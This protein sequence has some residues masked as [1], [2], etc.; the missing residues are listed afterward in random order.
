[1]RLRGTHILPRLFAALSL[2]VMLVAGALASFA[3]APALAATPSVDVFVGYADNLRANPANFPTPWTD[4]E[5]IFLGCTNCTYDAGAVRIANNTL[6]SVTVNALAIRMDTCVFALW[7]SALPLSLAPGQQLIVTQTADGADS[8]CTSNGHMDTSDVGPGG[9][10]WAGRCDNSGIIPEVDVTID[11]VSSSIPDTGRVLNTGGV[12]KAD[13]FGGANESTQWVPIQSN[14]CESASLTLDPS[15]QTAYLG[16]QASVT[17]TLVNGCND[18]LQGATV[19]FTV[20]SGPNAG[21][22]GSAPTDRD[23]H[24]TFNYAGSVTGQDTV[25]AEVDNPVGAIFSNSVTVDWQKMPTT[26]VYHTVTTGDFGDVASVSATLTDVHNNPVANEPVTITLNGS[27]SCQANTDTNGVAACSITPGELPGGSYQITASFA[28]DATHLGSDAT[29]VAF[30]VTKEETATV[31]TVTSATSSDYNDPAIVSATVTSDDG[32]PVVNEPVTFTLD[33]VDQCAGTTDSTGLASC[34]LTP[35]EQAGTYTLTAHFDGN[36]YYLASDVSAPFQVTLEETSLA[37]T[38]SNTLATGATTVSARLLEDNDP[39]T[40]IAGRTVSFTAVSNDDGTTYQGSGTTGTDGVASVDLQLPPGDYLL[41]A[42]FSSD[43][44]YQPA[45]AAA[46]AH[47]Y[48]YAPTGFSIW[49][50]NGGGT[51]ASPNVTLGGDYLFWGAQWAKQVTGGDYQATSSFKGYANSLS[52]DGSGWT[53]DPGNSSSPPSS[54]ASYIGVIVTT[55]V[56]QDG[57]AISGNVAEL[58]VVKVDNPSGYLP[59]P[60]HP[61]S[62]VVLAVVH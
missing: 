33:G 4:P 49:G 15:S 8:G 16:D 1:M 25:I 35:S 9:Q 39:N 50:G 29:P 10:G 48:V 13:C 26:L 7:S 23:G 46:Q 3:A 19:N 34:Q 62:G 57:S 58:V 56:Q 12:D 41:T 37:I 14:P 44:F 52:A 53:T 11:G 18:P 40:P 28:G 2:S 32:V 36:A 31:F 47:L 60:G 17:A 43:G 20:I 6:S 27:E 55:D 59:D 22:N 5:I 51:A 24:A 54:V 42:H 45:D 38:S 61:A 30:D 21:V